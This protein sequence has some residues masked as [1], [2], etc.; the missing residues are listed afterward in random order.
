VLDIRGLTVEI[1]TPRGLIR[2]VQDVSLAV[3]A[4]ETLAIVGESGSGKSVTATALMGLLPPAARA[5]GGQVW[6]AGR[7]LLGLDEAALRRLRGG[8]MAM[9]FQDPMSSLNPVLRVGEQLGEAI[10]AHDRRISAAALRARALQLFQRVGIADPQRRLAAYPHEMSGGMRQRVMIAMA[11]ANRPRLLIADEPTTALDVTVQ[12]QI[13]DLLADLK[14]ET[15]TAMIFITHSLGVVA[16]IADHVA[17]MYAGQVVEQGRVAEVFAAPLHPYTRALL[18]A[19]PEAAEMPEGIP[20][21]VPPPHAFPP[22]CRFAPRCVRAVPAC[23][24]APPA[25][26]EKAPGRLARCI[27]CAA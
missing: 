26:E 5:V 10:R 14:R 22:G 9:V 11:L 17:V 12:A 3:A 21:V 15:G 4:G 13:L 24:D 27:R 2:P 6:F 7:D 16:E 20:G 23:A 1:A 18:D 19:V 8:A 25:L